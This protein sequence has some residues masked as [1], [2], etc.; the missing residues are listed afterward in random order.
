MLANLL[1]NEFIYEVNPFLSSFHQSKFWYCK[2]TEILY[3][4]RESISGHYIYLSDGRRSFSR[5]CLAD[6]ICGGFSTNVCIRL[7]VTY[8]FWTTK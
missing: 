7:H 2:N 4:F 3:S 1:R 8:V 5:G 6:V